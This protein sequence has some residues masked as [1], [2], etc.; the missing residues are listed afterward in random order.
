M[1]S[2]TGGCHPVHPD[3]WRDA[4]EFDGQLRGG[5]RSLVFSRQSTT[6]LWMIFMENQHASKM[7]RTP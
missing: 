2:T 3:D 4:M 5:S 7:I 1:M 6:P